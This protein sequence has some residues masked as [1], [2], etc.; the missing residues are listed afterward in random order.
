MTSRRGHAILARLFTFFAA[1]LL[2]HNATVIDPAHASARVRDVVIRDGRIAAGACEK[3]I[4]LTDKFI[5]PGFFDHHA[6]LFLHAWDRDG[7]IRPRW[8]RE[9]TLQMLRLFLRFGVTTIRDPG[10]ET[11]AAVKLRDMVRAGKVV[12]PHIITA[13]RIINDGRLDAEPFVQL[14]DAD[15]IRREIQWQKK[16]G[17]D[18]IKI[19]AALPPDLVKVAIDEAH[20]QHLPIIGHM[21][22]TSWLQAAEMGIDGVEHAADWNENM[23]LPDK[24][25]AYD[26]SMFG[27]VYWLENLD[28]AAVDRTIAALKEHHVAVDPTL[29]AIATKFFPR[30]IEN[31]DNKLMPQIWQEGS[32]AGNFTRTWMP[33]QF[34]EAQEA[35]PKLLAFVKKIYDAGVPMIAGTDTPTPWIAPGASMHDE[36]VLLHDAGIPNMA[37]LKMSCSAMSEGSP[38]DLVVLTANPLDDIRNTRSIASVYKDGVPVQ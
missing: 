8:D 38:A 29:M 13:G 2:L 31:P 34:A 27:R 12:G 6:H 25:A 18:L 36:M 21:Q 1:C 4:D 15:A 16:A 14:R 30:W 22:A 28:S 33:V 32:A 17:V 19:Y 23:L 11:E 24:R 3:K 5:V 10:A 37:I 26:N 20:A 9:A 35:W 7:N